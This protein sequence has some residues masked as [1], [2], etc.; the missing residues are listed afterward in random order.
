MKPFY[1]L[2][3]LTAF[4]ISSEQIMAQK[5]DT[6]VI[7]GSNLNPKGVKYGNISYLVYNKKTKESPATGLYVANIMVA[8][9]NYHG[10]PAIA[11]TQKWN[12]RDTIAHTAYTVLNSSDLSTLY[13][14][15]S[16]LGLPYSTKFDFEQRKIS[17][18]G[19]ITDSSRMKIEEPFNESFGQHNLNWHSDLFI[20]TTLPFKEN[21]SFKINFYD[22]GSGKPQEVVYD[23]TG[24]EPLATYSGKKI[25][26]WVMEYKRPGN[27]YQRFWISKKDKEV[28]KE[29]DLFHSRYRYK[30]KLEVTD[31]N[32]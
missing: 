3:L 23:V 22:P 16:W 13:H 31:N 7:T 30:M 6:V 20:F 14:E 29:E 15:I 8:P 17:F 21:R 11:I 25:D 12:A 5:R 9:I 32:F 4:T 2:I 26:C 10:K 27:D 18:E 19:K 28:L 24:S 1:L